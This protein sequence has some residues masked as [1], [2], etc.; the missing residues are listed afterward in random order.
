MSGV[1]ARPLATFVQRLPPNS[2][3]LDKR[4]SV[5]GKLSGFVRMNDDQ[6]LGTARAGPGPRDAGPQGT[7]GRNAVFRIQ[8]KRKLSF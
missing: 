4:K 1:P 7:A 6:T 2:S 3:G 8:R 5:T